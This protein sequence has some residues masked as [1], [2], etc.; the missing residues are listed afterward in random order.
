MFIT[1]EGLDGSGS[2]TQARLLFEHFEKNKVP[3]IQTKEPT[4]DTPIGKL[5]REYL[6][7]KH[8]TNAQALQLLFA[9]DRENHLFQTI[10]PAIESNKIVISDRYLHSSI[11]FGS[12]C[13]KDFSWL[14][15]L[16][17]DFIQPDLVFLLQVDPKTC[18]QR[19]SER[20]EAFELFE[21]EETLT[22]IWKYYELLAQENDNIHVIDGHQSIEKI[23]AIITDTV[24]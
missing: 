19:I 8:K 16:Y 23:H 18:I 13:E 5:I 3:S 11:A 15:N 1:F 20:G 21:K 4:N 2:S 14:K 22:R 9:A 24:S 17:K 6:Q 10:L 12:H 7:H